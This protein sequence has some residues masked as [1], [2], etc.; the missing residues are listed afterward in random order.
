[1]RL[2]FRVACVASASLTFSGSP[3][4]A[5][6]TCLLGIVDVGGLIEDTGSSSCFSSSPLSV[7][8]G[9]WFDD[10]TMVEA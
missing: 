4:A 5:G 9:G 10:V 1:M 6:V 3:G 2:D 7:V 8:A